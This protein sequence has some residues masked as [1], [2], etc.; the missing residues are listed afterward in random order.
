MRSLSLMLLPWLNRWGATKRSPTSDDV[1]LLVEIAVSSVES[2]LGDKHCSTPR[3][4]SQ[5]TRSSWRKKSAILVHRNP[6]PEGYGSIA[7]LTETDTLTP[8]AAQDVTLA[9]RDLLG[10]S[11]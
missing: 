11:G 8:L 2:D 10:A 4:A 7:R 3:R 6:T 5:T 1:V 9:V